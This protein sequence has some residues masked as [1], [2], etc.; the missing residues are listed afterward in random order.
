MKRLVSIM[1]GLLFVLSMC[2]S[3]TAASVTSPNVK[4]DGLSVA[5]T[6]IVQ[7]DLNDGTL[8]IKW[9]P[10]TAADHYY[11]KCIGLNE[12]PRFGE[13]DSNQSTNG[14][15]L[16]EG[17]VT[18]NTTTYCKFTVSTTKM[19]PY[20]YLKI[21]V[22]AYGSDGTQRWTTFGVQL[23]DSSIVPV[24]APAVK[25]DGFAVNTKDIVDYDVTDGTLTIS[26][27]PQDSADHYYYKCIGLNETPRFGDDDSNQSANGTVLAEGTVSRNTTT[28]CKFTVSTTKMKQYP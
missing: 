11:Y 20:P 16:A 12:K 19:R 17:T 3:A 15:V 2:C 8:T 7:Y 5:A 4:C 28:Y 10:Q 27:K 22:A 14:T 1:I 6:E 9:T 25:C 18:K 21:A 26:W 13:G 24:T 23:S